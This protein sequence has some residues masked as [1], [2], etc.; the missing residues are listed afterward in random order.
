MLTLATH[1]STH[2]H[3]GKKKKKK[4]KKPPIGVLH[5]D[6]TSYLPLIVLHGIG[7]VEHVCGD[8]AHSH[9]SIT[10]IL[11]FCLLSPKSR[12]LNN[13]I[14][15]PPSLSHMPSPFLLTT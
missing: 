1:T 8:F 11:I 6:M 10:S 9:E 12:A 2:I 7:F 13:D 3:F 5:L 4:K 14:G 15:M